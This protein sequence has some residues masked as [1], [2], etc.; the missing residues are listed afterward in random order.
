ML[1]QKG[2]R[3]LRIPIYIASQAWKINL[4]I[5]Y[6]AHISPTWFTCTR[7]LHKESSNNGRPSGSPHHTWTK[8]SSLSRRHLPM[9]FLPNENPIVCELALVEEMAW[10]LIIVY[11]H[12]VH[13]LS[14]TFWNRKYALKMTQEHWSYIIKPGMLYG[15][16]PRSQYGH[17]YILAVVDTLGYNRIR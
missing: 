12:L 14:L 15:K 1:V 7:G 10:C 9:H 11:L 8:W 4:L 2:V 5:P 17:K 6:A 13:I 16:S 3:I